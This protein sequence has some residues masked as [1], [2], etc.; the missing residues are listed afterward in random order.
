VDAWAEREQAA[1]E[2][3]ARSVAAKYV[4]AADAE[5][6]AAILG[7]A[8]TVRDAVPPLRSRLLEHV[9]GQL[10]G[11]KSPT[12][13]R[14]LA[15]YST[16][17]VN[18]DYFESHRIP[19]GGLD[20]VGPDGAVYR[21]FAGQGLQFHPL[22]NGAK[23]N[24]LAQARNPDE[25]RRLADAL[26]AR[27]VPR[28]GT[29]AVWEYPFDFDVVR[30]PWTSGMA[31]AVLAQALARAAGLLEDPSLLELAGAAYRAVPGELDRDLGAGPW[32][33]LYSSSPLVVLNAQ[34][35]SALSL[36]EYA[37]LAGDADASAYTERLVGAARAL[38]ARF[39][40]G[41]WTRYALGQES[42]LAYH[43]YVVDL[44]ERLG[45]WTGDAFWVRKAERFERYEQ[46]APALTGVRATGLVY[47]KP[48]D[49]VRDEAGVRFWLSKISRVTLVVDGRAVDSRIAERGWGSIDWR[50]SPAVAAGSY[51]ARLVARDLA[52][53]HGTLE[54]PP[55]Q[56]A[57]DLDPPELAAQKA[58]GRVFWRVRDRE[59]ACCR[60]RLELR[61]EGG[62][63]VVALAARRRGSAVLADRAPSG[64]WLATLVALDAAGNRSE[65][66]LGLVVGR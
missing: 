41:S 34:L 31:Q 1:R 39:D 32:I 59:S 27:A 35:Q 3:L 42:T 55:I 63:A 12:A 54:L 66:E 8:R 21:Y 23:L 29:A 30:G 10:A 6:Y 50:P 22:A 51:P 28:P 36:G 65:R 25:A 48:R 61:R 60:M 43:Q 44:L 26:A 18:T 49:G 16:L 58:R 56:V 62:R 11:Y 53:N 57:R 38:L 24:A 45:R 2:A 46:E 7:R 5:R 17:E 20:V 33:R 4:G 19:S 52:G 14:A 64:Y 40:T 37:E 9:L 13:E 15:L 47:P